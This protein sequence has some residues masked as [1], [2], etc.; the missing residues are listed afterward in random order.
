MNRSRQESQ[1][2][3]TVSKENVSATLPVRKET[4]H[5]E[6]PPGFARS[7]LSWPFHNPFECVESTPIEYSERIRDLIPE[8]QDDNATTMT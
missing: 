7:M 3:T 4:D 5:R 6:T 8:E 2:V 1:S